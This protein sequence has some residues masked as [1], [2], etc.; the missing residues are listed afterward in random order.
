M[1]SVLLNCIVSYG[2]AQQS[3]DDFM[4]LSPA[5]LADI[6]VS[7][8]SGTAKALSQGYWLGDTIALGVIDA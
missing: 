2:Y 8:A 4:E 6:S 5:E 7:I 1:H 3:M